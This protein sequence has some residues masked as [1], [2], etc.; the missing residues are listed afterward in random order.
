[1]ILVALVLVYNLNI[2]EDFITAVKKFLGIDT[3]NLHPHHNLCLTKHPY[4]NEQHNYRYWKESPER[5]RRQ[6]QRCNRYGCPGTAF[7][8]IESTS[9]LNPSK[10][11][12][13]SPELKYY[14]NPTLY[15][16]QHPDRFPCPNFWKPSKDGASKKLAVS[17]PKNKV[18]PQTKTLYNTH[19]HCVNQEAAQLLGRD[20]PLIDGDPALLFVK[21]H[22][23]DHA[24]C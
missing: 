5:Y 6:Y 8:P 24:T 18:S 12:A 1:M 23:E 2:H 17:V 11:D 21:P 9:S 15:C 22:R 20:C 3:G 10:S 4:Y 16:Q 19:G 13:D 7:N 14:Q